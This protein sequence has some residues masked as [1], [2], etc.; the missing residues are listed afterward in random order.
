MADSLIEAGKRASRTKIETGLRI[1]SQQTMEKNIKAMHDLCDE[2]IEE[3]IQHPQ[4]ELHDL[5][6]TMLNAA[7][8]TTGEKLP[9]E[10]I[11]FQMV[12]F[13]VSDALFSFI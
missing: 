10:N 7:D 1:F 3:R 12:T 9:K 4:P 5:L 2:I 8:P 11:R 6:N 13:L